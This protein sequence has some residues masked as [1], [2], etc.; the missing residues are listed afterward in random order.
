MP[1]RPGGRGRHGRGDQRWATFVRNH[2]DA[3]VACDFLTTVTAGFRVLYV[4]LVMEVGSRTI[5]HCNVTANPTAEWTT[6]QLRGAIPYDHRRRF[7]IHDRDSV[8]SSDLDRT[9][10]RLGLQILKSP[11]RAPKANAF[12]ER[13]VGTARRE[14]FDWLIPL[15]EGHMR[16]I[17]RDWVRHYNEARP[18]A[19]LG[20]GIPDPPPGLPVPAQVDRHRLPAGTRVAATPILGGLHHE[21]RLEK[22]AA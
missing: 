17:L 18:H 2:A 4:F 5:L 14:C 12:C 9:V 7:L 1:K 10:E 15:S 11:V 19:S 20:P 21:Y 13:L 22:L 6:R 3:I 16:R 8:F